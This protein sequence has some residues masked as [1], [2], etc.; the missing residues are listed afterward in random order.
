MGIA[1]FAAVAGL[2]N[3]VAGGVPAPSRAAMV[4]MLANARRTVAAL[5]GDSFAVTGWLDR[6]VAH[7]GVCENAAVLAAAE[8]LG[9]D[10]DDL[11]SAYLARHPEREGAVD[12]ARAVVLQPG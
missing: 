6:E 2:V 12:T 9:T 11:L 1:G 3:P 4:A 10:G 8:R 7:S 5:G